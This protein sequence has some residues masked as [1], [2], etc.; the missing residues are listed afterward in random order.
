MCTCKTA[1]PLKSAPLRP[2]PIYS[3]FALTLAAA[4]IT[5]F[6][7][8]YY[9]PSDHVQATDNA[10]LANR[11]EEISRNCKLYSSD[12]ASQ[13]KQTIMVTI[14]SSPASPS[15]Q[16]SAGVRVRDSMDDWYSAD[17]LCTP[18]TDHAVVNML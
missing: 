5:L 12:D 4:A 13:S 18:V 15:E 16:Y 9:L 11:L 10:A 14:T 17:Y 2:P 8:V 7:S 3:L 6:F 1:A